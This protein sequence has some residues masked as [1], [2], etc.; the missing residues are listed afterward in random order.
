MTAAKKSS[1]QVSDAG[2][3]EA[4]REIPVEQ[5]ALSPEETRKTIDEEALAE[6]AKS[7]E[8]DGVIEPML[9]R[10]VRSKFEIVSGQR[11]W[12]GSKRAGKKTCPCI[13]REMSDEEAALIRIKS[14]LQRA[15]L[16]AMEEAEAFAKLLERDG[17]TT[18]TVA[19]E[20][21]KSPSYL[22][23]RVQLLK[24]IEPARQALKGGAIE[25]G[26][27]L[28]LARLDEAMQRKMLTRMQ[29][30]ATLIEPDDVEDES[31]EAGVCRFCG[32]TDDDACPGGCSWA[33]E[34]QTVCSSP[35]CLAQFRAETGHGETAWRKTHYS[36]VELRR[37]I[38]NSSHV[39]LK[40]APFPLIADL[41]PMPCTDCPKRAGNS[42]LLFDDCAQ[43]TCTDRGCFNRKVNARI[44][45]ELAAA[46]AEK[47][48][49]L[50]LTSNY[51]YGSGKK[52]EIYCTDY[53]GPRVLKA[54]GEC[55]HGEEAIWIDGR[56]AGRR[57]VV[58][59]NTNCK[60]HYGRST[61]SSSRSAMA[62]KSEKEKAARRKVLDRIK[63]EQ[64]YRNALAAAIAAAPVSVKVAEDLNL[65]ACAALVAHANSQYS[66]KLAKALGWDEKLVHYSGRPQLRA[67]LATMNAAQRLAIAMLAEECDE[68]S[69][70]EYTTGAPKGLEKLAKALGIDL[71]KIRAGAAKSA[72]PAPASKATKAKPA[73]KPILSAAARKRIADA[74][75]KRWAA[76]KKGGR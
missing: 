43:D 26:H 34:E 23:R 17:A 18:E 12:L 57:A 70:Q 15:E 21:A 72:A 63:G 74:Q 30:G 48:N 10:A 73:R 55:E 59:R 52:E 35:D 33:N 1:A 76:P 41:A 37:E 36:V 56:D 4:V 64:A 14:N 32:C 3:Q 31:G 66:A 19:A 16:P 11:R 46:K 40:N 50:K 42:Q 51:N 61:G 13:V 49:L 8:K 28:E 24:L 27:A 47:R 22:G 39:D 5:L 54:A 65:N 38:A 25:V 67:K 44:E 71:K 58:C 53:N 7:I 20:V 69:V 9:V 68:L 60:T 75:R 62:P 45:A 6:L 2:E 29:C